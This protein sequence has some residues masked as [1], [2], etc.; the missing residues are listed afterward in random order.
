MNLPLALRASGLLLLLILAGFLRSERVALPV[1]SSD[2]AFSW[3]LT[4][5]SPAELLRHM[6]G[7]AH[8][9]LYYLLLKGWTA[10]VGDSP[11]AL[12]GLSILFALASIIILYALCREAAV[13]VSGAIFAAFLFAIHLAPVDEPSRNARMYGQGVF[14]AG[15]TSWLLLRALRCS[16]AG[17][18]WWLGYGL[19]VAAFC[20]THYYAFFTVAA[21]T[22]FVTGDLSVRAVKN[23]AASVRPSLMGF[24]LAGGFAI[25]LYVPWLPVWWK[26]TND[27]R[28]GFWIQP[29]TYEHAKTVFFTW[30]SGLPYGGTTDFNCWILF[31]FG[32]IVWIMLK[33][34]RGGL[35]VLIAASVPWML[36]LILSA[37]SGRPIFHERYL[38]FAQF[39]LFAFW[40]IVWELLPSWFLRLGLGCF[41]VALNLSGLV[42]LRESWPT[43]PPPLAETAAFLRDRACPDDV[44]LTASPSAVNRLRYY[45]AQ[46]GM[47]TIQA[48]CILSPFQPPGH[49]VHLGSLQADDVLWIG[50][51][52]EPP[53]VRRIWT[54]SEASAATA[55]PGEFRREVARWYFGDGKEERYILIL[56]ERS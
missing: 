20:Y 55:S 46:A 5:Y 42:S 32:C 34:D 45:A 35:F 9:P 49:I 8:P 3:R 22:L 18:G 37:W 33:R 43:R 14:L 21:Q 4:T 36:S 50:F 38:F 6:P 12:R 26:Q 16:R 29:V 56:H 1:L 13:G 25:L 44:V 48:R 11:F 17:S 7:D 41:L 51:A 28:Q 47:P 52:S 31:L 23:S 39:F 53:T 40:G 30:S 19:A 2:E 27:V 10:L 15:L 54:L 24:L